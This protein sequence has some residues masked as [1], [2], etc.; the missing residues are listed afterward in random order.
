MHVRL[1]ESMPREK[2]AMADD[3]W[4]EKA[5]LEAADAARGN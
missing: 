4:T 2:P 3:R 5:G 1:E